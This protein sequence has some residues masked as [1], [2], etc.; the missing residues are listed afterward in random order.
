MG[1]AKRRRDLG[2]PPKVKIK[3]IRYEGSHFSWSQFSYENL[4]SHYPAAPFV[5]TSL[6]L[7]ILQW[8]LTINS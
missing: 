7:L 3:K 4:K 2:L 6:F 5:T 8:R 1:E